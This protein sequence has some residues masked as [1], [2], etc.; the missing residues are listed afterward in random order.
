MSSIGLD[1][2]PAINKGLLQFHTVRPSSLGLEAHLASMHHLIER[3]NPTLVVVDP[4]TNF[5]T[6]S[7]N[8]GMKS[9]LTRLVDFLKMKQITSLFTHLSTAGSRL[10]STDENVSSIMDAWMLL[11]DVEHDGHRS[12]AF[13]VLKCRG[14]AHSHE[15]RKF[16]LTNNGI[17]LGDIYTDRL[18]AEDQK[19]T[20]R[21][22]A[23]AKSASSGEKK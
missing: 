9:M 6:S 21:R 5:I 12:Y 7:D 1:L 8:S 10:E 16:M 2:Q 13:F 18:S 20:K 19:A 4:I 17:H 14:M 23:V 22:A 3:V 15:M 11:R